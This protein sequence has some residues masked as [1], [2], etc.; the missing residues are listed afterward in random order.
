MI[1]SVFFKW[2]FLDNGFVRDVL[3]T[4]DFISDGFFGWVM[5][6]FAEFQQIF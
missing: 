3:W 1:F 4:I 6:Y 5:F 2:Y